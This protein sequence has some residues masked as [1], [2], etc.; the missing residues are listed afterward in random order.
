MLLLLDALHTDGHDAL[1]C[2]FGRSQAT[3]V[4][5]EGMAQPRDEILDYLRRPLG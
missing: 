2:T 5:A 3:V 4:S 1:V